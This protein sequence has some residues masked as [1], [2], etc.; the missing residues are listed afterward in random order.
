MGTRNLLFTTGTLLLLAAPFFGGFF[1]QRKR[2]V[3][4]LILLPFLW[5]LH[6]Y[7]CI[8]ILD[9]RTLLLKESNYYTI[10]LKGNSRDSKDRLITLYLDSLN[11]SCSDPDN[12]F[13]LEYR[14]IQSYKEIIQGQ[15]DRKESF[16]TLFIGGG[17]YTFPRFI[18]ARYPNAEIDVVEIDPE[19]TQVSKKYLGISLTSKIQTFNEDGRWFVMN[20][21]GEERYDFIFEDAFN[22]LSIPYHLTT[23][24]FAI[25][26]KRLLKK[27][28]LLLTNVIDRFVKGSFLPSYIRTLEDVFGKG[29]VHL[30]TL[31]PFQ[32]DMGVVNRVVVTSPQKLD[33][34]DLDNN[35]NRMG[36]DERI[37]HIMPQEKLQHYLNQFS[38]VILT[39]DYVPIDNLTAP[40]FK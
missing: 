30:I 3:A 33:I 39:D 4:F 37:S 27:D 6:R 2:R 36:Q 18:E 13:R 32:D 16:K 21:K 10:R 35:F 14:Y 19:V 1:I 17:G 11:H 26:L 20:C 12:P 40:N 38:P 5:L 7:A 8:P 24:E 23:K 34:E 9:E 28:G 25:Q 31:G 22:D 15:A 29:N